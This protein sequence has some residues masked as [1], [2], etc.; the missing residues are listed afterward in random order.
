MDTNPIRCPQ[1]QGDDLTDLG[2]VNLQVAADIVLDGQK[3]EVPV[4][5]RLRCSCDYEFNY[6]IAYQSETSET[7]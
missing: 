7:D 3:Y 4:W 2:R 5:H 6:D 1:C